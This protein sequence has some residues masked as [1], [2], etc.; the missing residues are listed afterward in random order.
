MQWQIAPREQTYILA[1]S[2][3]RPEQ[4]DGH[5]T[6]LDLVDSS[7]IPCDVRWNAGLRPTNCRVSY[8]YLGGTAGPFGIDSTTFAHNVVLICRKILK[9]FDQSVRPTD[10]DPFRLCSLPKTEV[11]SQIALRNKTVATPNFLFVLIAILFERHLR[12]Q[13]GAVRFHTNQLKADEVA[14]WRHV[15][16]KRRSFVHVVHERLFV[17]VIKQVSE[18]HAAS[19]M[20]FAKG[21]SGLRGDVGELSVVQIVVGHFRLAVTRSQTLAVHL[22]VDVTIGNQNAG[23]PAVVEIVELDPP[24][25]PTRN[26]S[27]ASAARNVVEYILA[28]V[29]KECGWIVAD[30]GLDEVL[31]T[32]VRVIIRGDAHT[33]L[34]GALLV[35]RNTGHFAEFGEGAVM[36]VVK[37]KIWRRVTSDINVRPSFVIKISGQ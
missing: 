24:S 33:G 15:V 1:T 9:R 11:N 10:H 20:Q 14:H 7:Q 29:E 6:E 19:G 25:H 18:S 23:P 28:A 5:E 32:I 37:K 35:E 3:F 27:K 22:W 36:I 26:P 30:V 21:V 8:L 31:I 17:A 12:P 4:C 34:H 13:S 16:I 2:T